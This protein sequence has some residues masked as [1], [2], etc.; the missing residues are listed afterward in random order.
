MA[1]QL[2]DT[3]T[4]RDALR[5]AILDDIVGRAEVEATTIEGGPLDG[6]KVVSMGKLRDVVVQHLRVD[7]PPPTDKFAEV[8]TPAKVSVSAIC[9]DCRLPMAIIVNL[10]PQLT[11]TNDGAELAVKS[12]T[13]ARVHV[14]GQADLGLEADGQTELG[15][16]SPIDD[17]RLRILRAVA[18]VD[19]AWEGGDR[20]G[21]APTL[22]AIARKL[23]LASESD[24]GDLEE[25]LYAYAQLEEPLVEIDSGKGQPTTYGL[26]EA[27]IGLV[28]EADAK[29]DERLTGDG[30]E[31][32]VVDEPDEDTGEDG[33]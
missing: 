26:T 10:T 16:D 19:D 4:T 14:C 7:L 33:S 32:E 28:A 2:G 15:L 22:D 11:V 24:R 6:V 9:P 27:G 5:R 12:K 23:E 1:T 30:V 25:S 8:V 3:L 29:G 17:L 21:P 20:D 31:G 13:K 18:D